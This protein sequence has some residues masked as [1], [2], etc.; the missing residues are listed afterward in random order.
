MAGADQKKKIE[1]M[2][3]TDVGRIRKTNQDAF[4]VDLNDHLFVVADGMGGHAGGEVASQLCVQEILSY[5]RTHDRMMK[6]ASGG[7]PDLRLG[8][9]LAAAINHASLK[10]YEKALEEPDLKGMGTTSTLLKLSDG[11]AYCAHVGD[12]RLYLIREGFLYQ[13]THDHSLVNEQLRAG[14][15][16]KEQARLHERKN[17]IT[18]SVGYQ[19]QEDVDSFAFPTQPGDLLLVCSDG[20]HGKL[21]DEEISNQCRLL[22]CSAVHSL[23]AAANANGGDDNIT[24]VI[25]QIP[26]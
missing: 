15:I 4:L 6:G 13:I 24:A 26:S 10:I 11:H 8:S 9:V 14:L 16:S 23:I 22:K 20:L 25:V 7:H 17:V 18:R 2:G 12:S 19:E 3:A 5:L 21:T 1:A